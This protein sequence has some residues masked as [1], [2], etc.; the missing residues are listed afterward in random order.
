[1]L[2]AAWFVFVALTLWGLSWVSW[3]VGRDTAEARCQSTIATLRS[4][5]RESR[6]ENQRLALTRDR[7]WSP[8]RETFDPRLSRH[9]YARGES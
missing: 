5:L 7:S 9:L 1:M 6:L 4:D 3:V 2:S 8:E